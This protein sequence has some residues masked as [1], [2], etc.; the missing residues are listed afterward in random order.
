MP[1]HSLLYALL[2]S[3]LISQARADFIITVGNLTLAEG[4]A[5]SLDVN[6]RSTTGADLLDIFGAEFRITAA[7]GRRLE[8][9]NPPPDTQLNG[10]GY[11][12]AGDSVAA[13]NP[14]AGIIG[15]TSTTRDTYTGGDGTLSGTGVT[16]STTDELLVRLAVTA[17]TSAQPLAGDTFLISLVSG[18]STFFQDPS[19]LPIP[20]TR[21]PGMVTITPTAVPGPSGLVLSSIGLAILSA[22]RHRR[23]ACER[24]DNR[25]SRNGIGHLADPEPV[26]NGTSRAGTSYRLSRNVSL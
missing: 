9:V 18:P 24:A 20:F 26:P 21:T 25:P 14:P 1:R 17:A 4:G 13:T 12:F 16:V 15:T 10:P 7:S 11:V 3:G 19:P 5:G 2:L 6:I 8:F 22:L 23:L